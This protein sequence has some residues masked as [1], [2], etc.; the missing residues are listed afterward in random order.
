MMDAEGG[1]EGAVKVGVWGDNQ[2]R[3]PF[4]RSFILCGLFRAPP[5]TANAVPIH[6][7][8]HN[9]QKKCELMPRAGKPVPNI[10]THTGVV[11]DPSPSL[12]VYTHST[13]F[14]S[15]CRR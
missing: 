5:S 4:L 11:L 15:C 1:V 3:Q 7:G 2:L 6:Y 14:D 13:G 10:H 12:P 8:L 9:L